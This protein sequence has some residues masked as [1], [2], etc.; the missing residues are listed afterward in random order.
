M[1]LL[2]VQV[3]LKKKIIVYWAYWFYQLNMN[4]LHQDYT[5]TS[6][7]YLQTKHISLAVPA[8]KT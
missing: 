7:K 1:C 3:L 4:V 8:A 2:Y 5:L 6:K